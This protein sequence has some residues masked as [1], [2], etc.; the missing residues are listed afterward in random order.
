MNRVGLAFADASDAATS[1]GRDACDLA[2]IRA[3]VGQLEEEQSAAA[4][5]TADAG[6]AE[7][8]AAAR[9]VQVAARVEALARDIEAD[10]QARWTRVLVRQ[11]TLA[12]GA[13][14]A[15]GLIRARGGKP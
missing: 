15:S 3:R 6:A 13:F 4:E 8:A 10:N 1:R 5:A 12:L 7:E 14:V 11:A 9:E 2:R